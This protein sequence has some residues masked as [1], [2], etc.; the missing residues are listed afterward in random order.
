MESSQTVEPAP[1]MESDPS[2]IWINKAMELEQELE[3]N[4]VRNELKSDSGAGSRPG[5]VTLLY[6][7][8]QTLLESL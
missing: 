5:S 6:R 2:M 7:V 1:P 8:W 4:M 3:L